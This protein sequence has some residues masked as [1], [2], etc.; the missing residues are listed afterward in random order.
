M[1]VK[2]KHLKDLL[3]AFRKECPMKKP[4]GL[5]PLFMGK[6]P[7]D[8][9]VTSAGGEGTNF[10]IETMRKKFGLRVNSG[11]NGDDMKH[12]PWP[13]SARA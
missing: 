12:N 13:P 8:V 4:V 9:L 2:E 10:S 11:M 7:L 5:R 1:C 6:E 3:A